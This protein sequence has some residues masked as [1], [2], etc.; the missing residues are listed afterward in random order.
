MGSADRRYKPSLSDT[1]ERVKP[2]CPFEAVT[3]APG[4]GALC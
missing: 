4:T 2:V 3:V 1:A